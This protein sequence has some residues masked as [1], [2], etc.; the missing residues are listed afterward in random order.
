MAVGVKTKYMAQ[1][2]ASYDDFVNNVKL[3][4]TNA[5][6]NHIDKSIISRCTTLDGKYKLVSIDETQVSANHR[7]IETNGEIFYISFIENWEIAESLL[8]IHTDIYNDTA[9]AIKVILRNNI[10]NFINSDFYTSEPSLALAIYSFRNY[11]NGAVK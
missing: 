7:E 3:L 9:I 8:R 6:N 1:T 10:L 2:I 11:I 4:V 5:L